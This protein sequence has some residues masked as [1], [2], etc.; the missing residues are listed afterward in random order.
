MVKLNDDQVQKLLEENEELRG[1]NNEL[2]MGKMRGEWFTIP[3]VLIA[4]GV[5]TDSPCD[6]CRGL[7][8]DSNNVQCSV[9][10]GSGNPNK[11]WPAPEVLTTNLLN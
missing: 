2:T 11:P 10:R 7:G 6:A 4:R 1:K 8:C 3:E 5:P 9:C